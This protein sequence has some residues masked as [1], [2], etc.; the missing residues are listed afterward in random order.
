MWKKYGIT[1]VKSISNTY[2][3]FVLVQAL[4]FHEIVSPN[5]HNGNQ[6]ESL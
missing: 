6:T 3:V 1:E 2:L 4:L 5:V